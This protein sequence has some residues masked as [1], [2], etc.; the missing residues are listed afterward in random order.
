[1]NRQLRFNVSFCF[2]IW[3]NRVKKD[4]YKCDCYFLL[5][6]FGHN[7]IYTWQSWLTLNSFRIQNFMNMYELDGMLILRV[8]KLL[9]NWAL[10]CSI[11]R[12]L[13][14]LF[15]TCT[16][17]NFFCYGQLKSKHMNLIIHLFFSSS[18]NAFDIFDVFYWSWYE[19]YMIGEG[20]FSETV[21]HTRL[22]FNL[23]CEWI[24]KSICQ[25]KK[26]SSQ[27]VVHLIAGP[28]ISIWFTMDVPDGRFA[29]RSSKF[30]F[31]N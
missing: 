7:A 14:L 20:L 9:T 22:V 23:F 10:Q 27:N 3:N 18:F 28:K 4:L 5:L 11:D 25:C 30:I 12:L 21:T 29:F 31:L 8:T 15:E 16:K 24:K 2:E 26:I 19:R 13:Y 6:S 1:M 17:Y